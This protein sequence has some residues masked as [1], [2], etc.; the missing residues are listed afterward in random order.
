MLQ[1]PEPI[2]EQ[3]GVDAQAL[4][5]AIAQ[6]R[7]PIVFR[8]LVNDWPA[9]RAARA[10]TAAAIA[11]VRRFYRDATVGAMLGEPAIRGRFFY[12]ADLKS[13]NF[14]SVRVRLDTLLDDIE[15]HADD[16]LPPAIYV[17]STSVDTCLPGFRGENDLRFGHVEPLASVWIGNHARIAAHQDV[18][19]N[20]ACVVAGRR[21]FTLFPPD[22][23]DNLYIGPLDFT[24]AGQ[25]ISLVDFIAPDLERFPRFATAMRYARVAELGPGDAIYIP[26]LWWHH[27]ESLDDF[28][29]LLNYW[30]RR[31]PAWMDTPMTALMMAILSLR[32][33]PPVER[34]AWHDIFRHYVF[35][36]D[37]TTAAHIPPRARSLLAPLDADAARR[38][39]AQL[40]KRLNR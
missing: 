15:R 14:S 3:Q 38:L 12:G 21:R 11:Y 31:S 35:E 27:V 37:D 4:P 2:A 30:W 34:A 18:P 19:D 22:Q 17:G 5:A 29:L 6:A 28:N 36:A 20:L 39:R 33:L 16:P 25:A 13:F 1:T 24:P 10:S 32:D 8:G 7:H 40:L 26:S 23:L 9:V